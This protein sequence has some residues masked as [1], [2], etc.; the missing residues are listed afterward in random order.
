MAGLVAEILIV[1]FSFGLYIAYH[2]W[3]FLIHGT[4]LRTTK[5]HARDGRDDIFIRGK[6]ARIQFVDLVCRD[7]DTIAGIQQNRNA[8]LGVAF[9]AGTASLLAQKILSAILDVDQRDQIKA[10]TVCIAS[11]PKPS[12]R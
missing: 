10:F 7:N 11:S 9:L 3:F 2:V 1:C 8:L 4:G 12:S 5:T 6:I